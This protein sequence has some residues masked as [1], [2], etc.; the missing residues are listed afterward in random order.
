[1]VIDQYTLDG[2][3]VKRFH[4]RAELQEAGFRPEG[5][6]PS[7]THKP[8]RGYMWYH[9]KNPLK[10]GCSECREIKPIADFGKSFNS[11]DGRF[12]VC[13]PCR[14]K[15]P[16]NGP[17][18]CDCGKALKHFE[19]DICSE[20]YDSDLD[21]HIESVLGRKRTINLRSDYIGAKERY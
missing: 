6:P 2:A 3:F 12:S 5:L 7:K 4:S 1:M 18:K 20:C 19:K 14:T 9:A 15:I 11:V 21:T 13:R 10:K 16:T 8:Y 17:R